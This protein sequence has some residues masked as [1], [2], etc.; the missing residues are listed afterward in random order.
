MQNNTTTKVAGLIWEYYLK[1]NDFEKIRELVLKELVLGEGREE[2]E[3]KVQKIDT[4]LSLIIY[5]SGRVS[6]LSRLVTAVENYEKIYNLN[7]NIHKVIDV[8]NKKIFRFSGMKRHVLCLFFMN[9]FRWLWQIFLHREIPN[10]LLV[11]IGCFIKTKQIKTIYLFSSNNRLTEIYRIAA[12]SQKIKCVEFLHGIC[13]KEFS[14]YYDLLE[15]YARSSGAKN[16]YINM[17]PGLPQPK[18]IMRNM[19]YLNDRKVYFKN[20]ELWHSFS[21]TLIFDVIIIGGNSIDQD[22]YSTTYFLAEYLAAKEL[23]DSGLKV[24]YCPHPSRDTSIES[25]MPQGITFHSTSK[26]VKSAK[27]ILGNFSTVLFSVHLLGGQVLI[28]EGAWNIIPDD[29]ADLFSGKER[30]TY[31]CQKALSL[32]DKDFFGQDNC[33]VQ[34]SIDLESWVS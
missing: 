20:E 15:I 21:K 22:Y 29:L 12:L 5:D 8:N 3:L 16:H 6:S 13:S 30:Y 26:V 17:L 31:S 32:L 10:L 33:S 34:D 18:T 19:A 9:P 25:R 14:L 24:N 2:A 4:D 23:I 1:L 7:G 11:I 28:F 27:I